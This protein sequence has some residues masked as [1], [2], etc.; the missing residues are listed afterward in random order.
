MFVSYILAIISFIMAGMNPNLYY[1]FF[2]SV[3][4]CL[5]GALSEYTLF[6]RRREKYENQ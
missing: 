5:T 4:F 1:L 6:N 2:V 3:G